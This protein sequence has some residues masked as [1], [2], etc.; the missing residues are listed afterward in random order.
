[1]LDVW[2]DPIQTIRHRGNEFL[3]DRVAHK[4]EILTDLPDNSSFLWLKPDREQLG[5]LPCSP[6][7]Y[8]TQRE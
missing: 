7:P 6:E 2:P 1:M 5:L 3:T 8:G 4:G